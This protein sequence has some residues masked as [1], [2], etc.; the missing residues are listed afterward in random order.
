MNTLPTKIVGFLAGILE[1]EGG[2][3]VVCSDN[4]LSLSANMSSGEKIFLVPRWLVPFT[5]PRSVSANPVNYNIWPLTVGA[6][7]IH[8]A[9]SIWPRKLANWGTWE[10]EKYFNEKVEPYIEGA[11]N[12]PAWWWQEPD[13][14]RL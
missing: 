6:A 12:R 14:W 4:L 5:Y 1:R 10:A 11:H 7:E 9:T 3:R 13:K 2:V 8:V